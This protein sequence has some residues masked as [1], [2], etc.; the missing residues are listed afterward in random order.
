[1]IRVYDWGNTCKFWSHLHHLRLF[2]VKSSAMPCT[3]ADALCLSAGSWVQAMFKP[4]NKRLFPAKI[5][6]ID[7]TIVDEIKFSVIWDDDDERDR[8]KMPDEVFPLVDDLDRVTKFQIGEK[9]L[10]KYGVSCKELHPAVISRCFVNKAYLITWDDKGELFRYHKENEIKRRSV[11]IDAICTQRESTDA[12]MC[13]GGS[14]IRMPDEARQSASK[15]IEKLDIEKMDI[16]G[17]KSKLQRSRIRRAVESS[18]DDKGENGNC[19]TPRSE[20]QNEMI[21]E[22]DQ[23]ELMQGAVNVFCFISLFQN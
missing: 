18:D 23:T 17:K 4:L 7:R 12:A 19:V 6:H 5:A 8:L 13:V 14:A 16:D 10:A 9:V 11:D 1:M 21:T 3:T 20:Q 22:K 2:Y 15:A